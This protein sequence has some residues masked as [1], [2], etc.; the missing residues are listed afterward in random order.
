MNTEQHRIGNLRKRIVQ[1]L[2]EVVPA[3]IQAWWDEVKN[4]LWMLPAVC[5]ILSSALAV[6]FVRIDAGIEVDESLQRSPLLFGGGAE[7]ARG[8]LT[9]IA[10]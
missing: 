2:N 9:A 3:R 10:S 5:T 6:L 4:N 8:V 1:T 7:G